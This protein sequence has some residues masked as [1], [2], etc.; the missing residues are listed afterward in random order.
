MTIKQKVWMI[1]LI[2]TVVFGLGIIVTY[3]VSTTIYGVLNELGSTNIPFM[4]KIVTVQAEL[5]G[6]Q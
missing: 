2:A 1:P 6:I 5:K 3:R 4:Q